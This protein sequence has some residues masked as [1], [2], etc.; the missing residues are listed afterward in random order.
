M[1]AFLESSIP[2]NLCQALLLEAA[3]GRDYFGARIG[4]QGLPKVSLAKRY[5]LRKSCFLLSHK[6]KRTIFGLIAEHFRIVFETLLDCL[7]A[8]FE[9]FSDRFGSFSDPIRVNDL[10]LQAII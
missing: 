1:P 2:I 3:S 6:K 4:I 5:T 10:D 7:S 9:S 8:V